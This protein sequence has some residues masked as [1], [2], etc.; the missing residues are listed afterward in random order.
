MRQITG[1]IFDIR[2][3]SHQVL[4]K[5]VPTNGIVKANGE[6]VMGAGVAKQMAEMYPFIPME[7]GTRLTIGGNVPHYLGILDGA[8]WFSFPVKYNFRDKADPQLIT[9]SIIRFSAMVDAGNP[10][11]V[12]MPKVGCGN[13]KLSWTSVKPMLETTWGNDDRLVIVDYATCL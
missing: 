2:C 8:H 13:G 9:M 3:D 1:D 11:F 6:A 10:T 7:L 5:V 4:W 12:L